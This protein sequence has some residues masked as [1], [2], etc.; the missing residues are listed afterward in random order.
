MKSGLKNTGVKPVY[1]IDDKLSILLENSTRGPSSCMG[2]RLVK[3]RERRIV[4][5]NLTILYGRNM[6]QN[7]LTGGFR[8]IELTMK[9]ERTLMQAC[10]RTPDHNN[11]G[12]LIECHLARSPKLHKK[13]N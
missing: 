10:S 11:C 8:E 4:N 1:K 7:F 6:S 5:E 3:R 9:N 2:N 13:S 12:Q